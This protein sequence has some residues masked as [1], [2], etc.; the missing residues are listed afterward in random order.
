MGLCFIIIN[1]DFLINHNYY[2][3]LAEIWRKRNENGDS[4]LKIFCGHD[5]VFVVVKL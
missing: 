1:F 5:G 2:T 3:L 4:E